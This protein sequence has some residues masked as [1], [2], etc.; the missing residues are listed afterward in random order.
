MVSMRP[1]EPV[2]F[3]VIIYEFDSGGQGLEAQGVQSSKPVHFNLSAARS[4]STPSV[5]RP[6]AQEA[7]SFA[8]LARIPAGPRTTSSW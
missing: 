3:G 8:E 5:R 7:R 4:M 1:G 6:V 2:E